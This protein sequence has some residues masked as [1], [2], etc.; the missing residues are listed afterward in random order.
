VNEPSPA[1]RSGW[2][3]PEALLFAALLVLHLLPVWWLEPFPTQDGPG[4]QAV[5]EILRLYDR[6][7]GA[8]LHAYYV[9]NER[10]SPNLFVFTVMTTLLGFLPV[11]AAEKV[12]LAAY[13]VLLPVSVRYALRA[14]EPRNAALALLAFPFAYN[15]LL[16][17]G[18]FN[19]CFSLAAFFFG[20]GFWWRYQE[21]W[22]LPRVVAFALLA[23][24]VYFCHVVSFVMLVTAVGTLAGWRVLLDAAGRPVTETGDEPV[25]RTLWRGCRRRLAAPL[26]AFVPALVLMLVFLEHHRT[27][28]TSTLPLWVKVKHFASLYSLVALDQRAVIV[29]TLLALLFAAV[30]AVLLARAW[31]RWRSRGMTGLLPTDGLLLV[32]AVFLLVYFVAPSEL[33]G[34]GFLVHRLNLYPFLALI[35]WFATFDYDRRWLASIQSTAAVLSLALLAVFWPRWRMLDDYLAEYLTAGDHIAAGSTVLALPF[36]HHGTMPDGQEI[37]FRTRPFL[38]ALGH[39][40]ARKPLVDLG[41]YEANEDYFPIQ[42]PASC[43][44][45]TRIGLGPGL[46]LE[47]EPPRVD[48]LHYPRRTGRRVDYVLLWQLDA[49]PPD[50]PDVRSVL[51]QLAAAYEPVYVSRR[52]LVRLYRQRPETETPFRA[53]LEPAAR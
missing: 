35:L 42:F 46:G 28:R 52:G 10:H 41:L 32:V 30:T 14:I 24:A 39:I 17:M 34:G 49:A 4:H 33:S 20:L 51:A 15:Y 5:A 11:P 48:F 13:V 1:Q 23:L 43:N 2:R 21:R 19:F 40:A 26:A 36:S 18:F 44:P 27:A 12:L 25:L 31:R 6:P 53:R 22:S 50:H 9:P 45:F 7:E 38:H 3:T 37:A 47:G 29:S 16:Q 8:F